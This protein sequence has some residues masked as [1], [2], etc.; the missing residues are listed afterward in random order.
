MKYKICFKKILK[1]HN[2]CFTNTLRVIPDWKHKAI[3]GL[4]EFSHHRLCF[5]LNLQEMFF[6]DKTFGIDFIDRFGA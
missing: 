3:S 4:E 2:F 6:P 1:T 5:L